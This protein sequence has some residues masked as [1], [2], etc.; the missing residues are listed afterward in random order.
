MFCCIL[1]EFGEWLLV[2][3]GNCLCLIL[4]NGHHLSK[5]IWKSWKIEGYVSILLKGWVDYKY[6]IWWLNLEENCLYFPKSRRWPNF[7]MEFWCWGLSFVCF[8]FHL[9]SHFFLS[10]LFLLFFFS[11]SFHLY[12][13]IFSKTLLLT[14][15]LI[16]ILW[17]F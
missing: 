13:Q 9:P 1:V 6:I 15:K 8:L 3:L 17:L 16:F 14:L 11:H 12:S 10:F 2:M 7:S 5:T 4:L